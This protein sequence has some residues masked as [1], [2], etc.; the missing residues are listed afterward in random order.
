MKKIINFF[1]DLFIY[2]TLF[3]D[4]VYDNKFIIFII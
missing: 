1:I 4:F 2:L 3:S